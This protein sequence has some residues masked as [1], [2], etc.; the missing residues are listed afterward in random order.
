MTNEMLRKAIADLDHID[1]ADWLGDLERDMSEWTEPYIDPMHAVRVRRIAR[2]ASRLL[3]ESPRRCL[4]AAEEVLMPSRL[5]HA[6]DL[7][8]W[9]AS[10]ISQQ[11]ATEAKNA[12]LSRERRRQA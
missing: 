10:G 3:G 9:Y 4:Q 11:Q 8:A 6:L 5:Q 12:K 1:Q 2:A 7:I